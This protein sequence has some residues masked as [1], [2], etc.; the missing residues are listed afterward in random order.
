MT[1]KR[2]RSRTHKERIGDTQE[3]RRSEVMVVYR[4]G[5]CP[6]INIYSRECTQ[7]KGSTQ[8]LETSNGRNNTEILSRIALILRD[9]LPSC[10]A[11]L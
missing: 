9:D 4:N 8:I 11:L 7:A 10:W 6:Q 1:F 5:D 2:C 3:K